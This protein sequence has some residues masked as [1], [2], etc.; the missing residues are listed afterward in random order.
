[1]K[2]LNFGDSTVMDAFMSAIYG[3]SRKY[4]GNFIELP[5]GTTV[6]PKEAIKW[7]KEREAE[8]NEQ[9]D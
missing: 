5:D 6:N 2:S 4:K 8:S 7:I 3:T 1:M 9:G